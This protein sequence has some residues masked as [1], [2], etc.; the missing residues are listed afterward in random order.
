MVTVEKQL[1]VCGLTQKLVLLPLPGFNFPPSGSTLLLPV[2]V[3]S[4]LQALASPDLEIPTNTF[5][6]S[7][8][9][10]RATSKK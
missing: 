8:C 1:W 6:T 4:S 10:M 5:L 3:L 2:T 7:N 9:S